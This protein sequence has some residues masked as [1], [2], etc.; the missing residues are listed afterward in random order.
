[1]WNF[2]SR[3]AWRDRTEILASDMQCQSCGRKFKVWR[4]FEIYG[5]INRVTA[6]N[7]HIQDYDL[8]KILI[9]KTC[10][11]NYMKTPCRRFSILDV[12]TCKAAEQSSR[13]FPAPEKPDTSIPNMYGFVNPTGVAK[14]DPAK[15]RFDELEV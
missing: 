1:M 12:D 4:D 14:K 10:Y 2:L 6:N 5:L 11:D 7:A 13:R 8:Y 15:G 3:H 9:C